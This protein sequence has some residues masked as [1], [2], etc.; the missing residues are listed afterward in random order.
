VAVKFSRYKWFVSHALYLQK[1]ELP[2]SDIYNHQLKQVL[3]QPHLTRL[4]SLGLR[5]ADLSLINF[6]ELCAHFSNLRDLDLTSV[7][8]LPERHLVHLTRMQSLRSLVLGDVAQS[9]RAIQDLTQLTSLTLKISDKFWWE[10]VLWARFTNLEVLD[11][12]GSYTRT[13]TRLDFPSESLTRVTR[14][15]LDKVEFS[16]LLFIRL[17][18]LPN[19]EKLSM[20]GA[21]FVC[22]A[23]DDFMASCTALT[24]LSIQDYSGYLCGLAKLTKL[25][26]L[27]ALG[28]SLF[29][30]EL[31]KCLE[32]FSK[33]VSLSFT[34]SWP[35][36]QD[37][38][39]QMLK[40]LTKL[41]ALGLGGM[42]DVDQVLESLGQSLVNLR[43]LDFSKSRTNRVSEM[44]HSLVKFPHLTHVLL[45]SSLF[46]GDWF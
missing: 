30:D 12:S 14:L 3:Q 38:A 26:E 33:L 2:R 23:T 35:F 4:T 8:Y 39:V 25:R 19:L 22:R 34:V 45:P 37:D 24:H 13:S 6:D 21:R 5:G 18:A 10:P 16:D 31:P 46:S 43:S 42:F 41:R 1:L 27:N 15:V 9:I 40:R 11:L 44:T 17:T 36:K 7:T 32:S 29:K 28:A 20:D